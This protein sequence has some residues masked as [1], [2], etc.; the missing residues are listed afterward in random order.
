MNNKIKL[1]EHVFICGM[2]GCG[3]TYLEMVYLSG[4]EN[5]IVLDTKGL[6]DWSEIIPNV[7]VFTTLAELMEF[8]EGKAIYRPNIYECNT[9]FYDSFFKWIYYRRNTVV[10]IDEAMSVCD[11]A[12][13]LPFWLKALYT[14]GR[15]LKISVFACTQRPKSIPLILLSESTHFFVF[16]LQMEVDR[17]RCMEVITHKEIMQKPFGDLGIEHGFW[18]YNF[19]L[20]KPLLGVLK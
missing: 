12:N 5:V 11:S 13:S 4:F 3:K 1:G 15:E 18:Y 17:K 7:P 2:T 9:E 6:F 19:R 16:D 20:S 14:R 8:G 10:A